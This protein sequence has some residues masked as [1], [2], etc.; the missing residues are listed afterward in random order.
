MRILSRRSV[1][2]GVL[3]RI[4][5]Y[6]LEV[7]RLTYATVVDVGVALNRPISESGEVAQVQSWLDR[8]EARIKRRIPNLDTLAL[9]P[10]Y[11]E[12]LKGVEVEV[13]VRRVNNPTG[14]KNERVDDYSYGLTDAAASSDLWPTDGEWAEL[15]P[16]L[17]RGA[18]TVR[19]R[20]GL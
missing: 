15:M 11:L 6:D 12:I 8:V 2:L 9:D 5:L 3:R 1:V 18:F 19:P 20:W 14:K 17:P 13:V 16:A 10:D 7:G 4:R